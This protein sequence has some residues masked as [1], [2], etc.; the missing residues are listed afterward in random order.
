M[1]KQESD[2]IARL[3]AANPVLVDEDR[4]RG[5]VA[6]LALERILEDRGE[7]A[8]P[9]PVERTGRRR[10]YLRSRRRVPS[11][12]LRTPVRIVPILASLAITVAVVVFAIGIHTHRVGSSTGPE[13]VSGHATNGE[14]AF[15]AP[16]HGRAQ[17]FIVN[18]DGTGLR[19]ITHSRTGQAGWAGLSWSPDGRGL[20][21]TVTYPHGPDAM[22]KSPADG[23]G[24]TR[25]SPPCTGTC[26]GDDNPVYS[27]DGKK[28]AFERAFGPIVNNNASGGVAIFT[29]NAD[30][31]DLRQLTP[32]KTPTIAEHHQPQWSPDGTRIAFVANNHTLVYGPGSSNSVTQGAIEVMNADGSNVRRL[33]PWRLDATDPRWSP[34]GKRLLFNTY[35][36][37]FQFKS[38]NL[39]TMRPDGTDRVALTHYSGGYPQ[40]FAD[41]W[42]PDGTQIVYRLYRFHGCCTEVGDYYTIN[43]RTKQIRRLTHMDFPGPANPN[44]NELAVWGRRPG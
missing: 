41:G 44:S 29:M 22:F 15:S 17:V 16:A 36:D 4:G 8:D 14:I 39:F 26:L 11:G 18:P 42:S 34:D 19:Q 28:I 13:G 43:L 25:I 1:S 20:L 21:Y 3:R 6:Q 10:R 27:P 12:W 30:G 32:K 35:A 40:A 37:A 7:L 5:A 38:A 33:T 23:S 31:S 9:E 24:A 2:I